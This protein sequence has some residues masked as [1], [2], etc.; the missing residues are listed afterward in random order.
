MQD[1]TQRAQGQYNTRG[2]WTVKY[3]TQG[4]QELYSTE[5]LGQYSTGGVHGVQG[6]YR[7]QEAQGQHITGGCWTVQYRRL[8]D[9]TVQWP[10]GHYIP[11]DSGTAQYM[12]PKY[13]TV[14]LG[15]GTV[16]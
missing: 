12:G 9:S 8:R 16:H 5:A 1:R 15:S 3:R 10:Q 14:Q 7:T 13:S 6:Q 11:G 2:A 4:A